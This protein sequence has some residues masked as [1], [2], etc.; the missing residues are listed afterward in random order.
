MT[1]LLGRVAAPLFLVIWATGFVVARLVAPHAEPLTFL[2]LRFALA[3]LVPGNPGRINVGGVDHRP[4]SINKGVEHG[5]AGLFIGGPAK[6]VP[7]EC[8]GCNVE[9]A[10][11]DLPL[12]HQSPPPAI[13]SKHLYTNWFPPRSRLLCKI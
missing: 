6:Y 7:A 13:T 10:A 5:K 3:A 9:R 1:W 2:C 4:A 8:H 11:A 12:V